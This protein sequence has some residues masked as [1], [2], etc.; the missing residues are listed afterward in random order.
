MQFQLY[1]IRRPLVRFFGGQG[2]RLDFVNIG[3]ALQAV[4]E[5]NHAP[6]IPLMVDSITISVIPRSG[7]AVGLNE[8]ASS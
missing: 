8:R 1:E 3:R 6:V 2:Q 5:F 7:M 4:Q